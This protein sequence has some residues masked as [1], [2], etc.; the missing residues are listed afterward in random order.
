[1][2]VLSSAKICRT[3]AATE[4]R[5]D[6]LT[7]QHAADI[8]SAIERQVG[9]LAREAI[10]E[11]GVTPSDGADDGLRIGVEEQLI[12]IEAVAT[13]G[14]AGTTDAIAVE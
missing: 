10:A 11:M 12:R 4:G 1:M 8:V 6:L 9:V 13:G 5:I 2:R 7:F 3:H 14:F